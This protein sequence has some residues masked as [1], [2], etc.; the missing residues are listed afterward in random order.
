MVTCVWKPLCGCLWNLSTEVQIMWLK[1]TPLIWTAY[2]VHHTPSYPITGE[3]S[4]THKN[5]HFSSTKNGAPKMLLKLNNFRDHHFNSLPMAKSWWAYSM[6]SC[7]VHLCVY[8]TKLLFTSPHACVYLSLDL[9]NCIMCLWPGQHWG[10][11]YWSSGGVEERKKTWGGGGREGQ[12]ECSAVW[13]WRH[14][15]LHC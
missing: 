7:T 3:T 5:L 4:T 11:G 6:C 13:L 9:H 10:A 14:L 1:S 12:E 8:I 2:P 15:W